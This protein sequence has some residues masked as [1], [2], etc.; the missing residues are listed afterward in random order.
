[1]TCLDLFSGEVL[2]A[3]PLKGYGYGIG[4]LCLPEKGSNLQAA[5]AARVAEDARRRSSEAAT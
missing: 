3:N 2:W 5:V 4:G 1:L